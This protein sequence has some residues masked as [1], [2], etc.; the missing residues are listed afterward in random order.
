MAVVE[1]L[2][3][4]EAYLWALLS[5]ESGIDQAEFSWTDAEQRD[6]CFRAWPFQWSWWRCRDPLQ[7]D[8]CA[9]SVG[10]SLSIK[11][12]AFA[13]PFLHPGQEMVI[14]APEGVHLDAVTD[15]I[16]TAFYNT[17][18]GAEMMVK[19]VRGAV[20]HKPFHMNFS[21]GARIMGRIPQRDG[22]GVKGIHPLWLELD[23]AQDYPDPG[24][25][26]LTETLKRGHDGAIWRAHGVTRGVRDRFFKNSQADSSWTVHRYTAQSR[27]TW[28]NMERLEKIEQYGGRDDPDYR[29]NVL[30]EH[31]DATSPLFVLHRLMNCVDDNKVSAYNTDEYQFFKISDSFLLERNLDIIEALQFPA[32]H[33]KYKTTWVGYDVGFTNHPSELLVFAEE[34]VSAVEQ[35]TLMKLGKAIPDDGL[36]RLKLLT[37]VNLTRIGVSDQVKTILWVVDFYRPEAFS[38][39]KTGNGL[40]LFQEVQEKNRQQATT[41]KG[42]G[43]SEKI[44]VDFDQTIEVESDATNAELASKA[45]IRRN[46]VDYA[47][48]ILRTLVDDRR[49]WLPWDQDLIGEFMGQT[50]KITKSAMD[51]YGKRTYSLGKF[52]ALDAA[53]MAVLGWKQYAIEGLMKEEKIEPVLDMF[54][55]I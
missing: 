40:P 22:R 38:M 18:L 39:D 44:L 50:F 10:K 11:V 14:T 36:S 42:Y 19:G 37:R 35:K 45:G 51:Q 54:V 28:T 4:E 55:Q 43:F 32:G 2:T 21:N 6:N 8:Q 5:D 16:E 53:R 26:E 30:G 1:D 33:K 15:V 46:T 47:T 7:L 20:K 48:D 3:E 41:I 49:L 9:R 52:H 29:R 24:W 13:F 23:E 31:G 12:R 17:R 34:R 27:P 25:I